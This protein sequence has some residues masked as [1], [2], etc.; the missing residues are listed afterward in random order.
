MCWPD[1]QLSPICHPEPLAPRRDCVEGSLG[2]FLRAVT[3]LVVL[4]LLSQAAKQCAATIA[5]QRQFLK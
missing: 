2:T 4:V 3:F 5:I 1:F